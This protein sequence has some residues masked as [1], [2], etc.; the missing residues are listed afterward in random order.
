[1]VYRTAFFN[2]EN[3]NVLDIRNIAGSTNGYTLPPE[4]YGTSD[5]HLVLKSLLPNEMKASITIDVIRLKS[6]LTNNTTMKFAK[7]SFFHRLLGSFQSCPD[8]LGY[9]EGF[10]Q[11]IPGACKCEKPISITG[12]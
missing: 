3:V 2:G 4:K 10:F 9:I 12:I 6:R 7:K 5:F 1:M 8:P 11:K